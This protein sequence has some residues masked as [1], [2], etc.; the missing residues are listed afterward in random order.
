MNTVTKL[1]LIALLPASLAT[2]FYFGGKSLRSAEET[3]A[4]GI[5]SGAQTDTKV[6][7]ASARMQRDTAVASG[8]KSQLERLQKELRRTVEEQKRMASRLEALT[9]ERNAPPAAAERFMTITEDPVTAQQDTDEELRSSLERLSE[10]FYSEVHDEQ[11]SLESE[12]TLLDVLHAPAF[13]DAH[14]VAAECR[15]TLCRV[16]FD[17]TDLDAADEALEEILF[18]LDWNTEAQMMVVNGEGGNGPVSTV[19]F[20]SRDGYSLSSGD[21]LGS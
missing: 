21:P 7:V 10:G 1:S 8:L 6:P 13:S 4:A 9:Q 15:S 12:Q 17:Y 18:S 5:Q 14:P 3:V 19:L 20:L 16:E 2:G 11:W